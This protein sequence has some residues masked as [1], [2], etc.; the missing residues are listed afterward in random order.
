MP[1]PV[2]LGELGTPSAIRTLNSRVKAWP[3]TGYL[4]GA[5]LWC[6]SHVK[7]VNIACNNHLLVE[8]Q[9][10]VLLVVG[11]EPRIRTPHPK[12]SSR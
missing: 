12:V 4:K 6:L 1:L 8:G 9:F 11:G 10:V 7:M 3:V 5:W 2:G